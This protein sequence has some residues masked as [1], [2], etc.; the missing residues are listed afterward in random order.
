[1]NIG[2]LTQPDGQTILEDNTATLECPQGTRDRNVEGRR[3]CQ[4]NGKWSGVDFHCYEI[5][6]KLDFNKI[7]VRAIKLSF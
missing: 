2:K 6:N 3:T 5:C 7:H 1:M 4:S